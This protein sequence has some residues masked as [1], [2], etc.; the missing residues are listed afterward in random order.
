MGA[1]KESQ[2]SLKGVESL[3]EK[4]IKKRK[5]KELFIQSKERWKSLCREASWSTYQ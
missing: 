2:T 1:L 5:V 4:I 3:E